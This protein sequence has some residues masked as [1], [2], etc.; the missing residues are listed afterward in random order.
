MLTPMTVLTLCV[1]LLFVYPLVLWMLHKSHMQMRSEMMDLADKLLEDKRVTAKQKEIIYGMLA[2][3]HDWLAGFHI[4][5]VLP[6]E[7]FKHVV[8]LKKINNHFV[9]CDDDLVE[10]LD[11][12]G[13]MFLQSALAA[14]P[15]GYLMFLL[16]LPML[17]ICKI[18]VRKTLS[19]TEM[20]WSS[21]RKAYSVLNTISTP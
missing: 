2:C 4:S 8:G 15:V 5:I 19:F 17:W 20:V 11:R 14:F 12:Y 6:I 16:L 10:N 1:I 3:S 9:D 21:D 7:L 18:F 13:K